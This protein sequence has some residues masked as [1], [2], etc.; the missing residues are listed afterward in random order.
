MSNYFYYPP[1]NSVSGG[2][3]VLKKTE[4]AIFANSQRTAVLPGIEPIDVP[5]SDN[6]GFFS[7]A[8][9]GR[10]QAEPPPPPIRIWL[11]L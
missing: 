10:G 4:R 1:R 11:I 5:L 9:V 6:R 3:F 8:F 7:G 2:F